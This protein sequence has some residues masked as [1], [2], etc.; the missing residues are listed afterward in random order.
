MEVRGLGLISI[1]Q[2]FGV[3]SVRDNKPIDLVIKLVSENTVRLDRLGLVESSRRRSSGSSGPVSPSRSHRVAASPCWS[4]VRHA[5]TCS[6]SGG[7]PTWR[8]SIS[9]ATIDG[10]HGHD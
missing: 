9:C 2:L 3:V 8:A 7:W 10:S 5:S 4:S 1:E 6:A